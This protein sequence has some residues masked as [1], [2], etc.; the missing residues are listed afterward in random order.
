MKKKS[1]KAPAKKSMKMPNDPV[2][3][4]VTGTKE[5]PV[6]KPKSLTPSPKMGKKK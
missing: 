4:F 1:V 5:T 3:K 2:A 6:K